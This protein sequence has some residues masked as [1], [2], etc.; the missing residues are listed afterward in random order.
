MYIRPR[1]LWW[2]LPIFIG[3]LLFGMALGAIS[4]KLSPEPV[5]VV[6]V[7][8]R[9]VADRET[10]AAVLDQ[11]SD[12][13]DQPF[14]VNVKEHTLKGHFRGEKFE[15]AGEIEG[16]RLE[17]KRNDQEVQ[18]TVDG[19]G[20][21][22]HLLPYALYTPYEHAMLLKAHLHS[23]T[24]L[25]LTDNN[26][27]DLL[28]FHLTMQPAE[29]TQ[30]LELWLGPSFPLDRLSPSLAKQIKVEYQVWYDANSKQLKQLVVDLRM[31]TPAGLKQDQL[32]FR[33]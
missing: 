14:T 19:E 3:L 17:L 18:V 13:Q 9:A 11:L 16:H 25:V 28:G 27:K 5:F 4:D 29:V 2:L 22:S 21:D 24:P 33:L 31:N 30:L 10:I 20:Q 23:L 12:Q 6:T 8:E 7:E 26:R 1:Q 32:L 15:L